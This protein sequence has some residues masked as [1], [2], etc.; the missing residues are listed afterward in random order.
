MG[1]KML[2][3]QLL[4]S[5]EEVVK[6]DIPKGSYFVEIGSDRGH[7]S[8]R[9]LAE[10]SHRLGYNF[11]TVDADDSISNHAEQIVKSVNENFISINDLGENFLLNFDQ[12]IHLV[13]LD[14][15]DLEHM[16]DRPVSNFCPSTHGT[17]DKRNVKLTNKN[18]WKMHFDCAKILVEKMMSGGYLFFDDVYSGFPDWDGKGKTA[19]PFLLE[20]GFTLI[21]Y[22]PNAAIF[23]KL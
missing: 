19:I 9:E 10:M 2:G 7:G 12:E 1:K 18:C 11:I 6:Y 20:N 22:K 13:Y 21:E 23:K 14:A 3:H 5:Y 4:L 8:T 15:F 16:Q 17:Y